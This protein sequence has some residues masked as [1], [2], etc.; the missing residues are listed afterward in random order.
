MSFRLV[1]AMIA[2]IL[3]TSPADAQEQGQSL[4]EVQT[5]LRRGDRIRVVDHNGAVIEGRFEGISGSSLR[6]VR[7]A[8]ALELPEAQ[9]NRIRKARRESDGIL[10]GLGIGAAAGLSY[11]ALYCSGSSEPI[12]C[13]RAGSVVVIGPSAVAGALIDRAFRRFETV[14]DRNMPSPKQV[15]ISPILTVRQKGV[16]IT[17]FY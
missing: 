6:L 3:A 7:K 11:V 13:R 17:L 8:T 16:A 4:G 10:I 14:F 1:A 12:D 5:R 9:I 2:V 15:R